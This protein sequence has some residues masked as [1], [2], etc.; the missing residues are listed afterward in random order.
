MGERCDE[1]DGEPLPDEVHMGE[2]CATDDASI[3]GN[4]ADAESG[5]E[6]ASSFGRWPFGKATP[7]KAPATNSPPNAFQEQL[8]AMKRKREHDEV[9]AKVR[10][11]QL[12]DNLGAL[13]R[14]VETSISGIT[15]NVALL[16]DKIVEAQ[17]DNARQLSAMAE[18]V[19]DQMHQMFTLLSNQIANL[20]AGVP[21]S[22]NLGEPVSDIEQ[23]RIDNSYHNQGGPNHYTDEEWD[24]CTAERD[25]ERDREQAKREDD[26]ERTPRGSAKA[27]LLP[28]VPK[29]S[30]VED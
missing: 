3:G 6:A 11:S 7:R 28:V 14:E 18:S 12:E 22:G 5:A 13:A 8:A 1:D 17:A 9:E 10:H 15:D 20:Q 24:K 30:V 16:S 23:H 2:E 29:R 4:F 26:R 21:V 27:P 25:A 19:K